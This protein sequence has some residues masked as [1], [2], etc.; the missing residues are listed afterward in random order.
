MSKVENLAERVIE[1]RQILNLSQQEAADL[2]GISLTELQQFEAEA[3]T[4]GTGFTIKVDKPEA[5]KP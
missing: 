2:I 1:A 5:A 4:K 3:I